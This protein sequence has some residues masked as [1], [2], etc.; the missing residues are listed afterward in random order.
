MK[1][2]GY[3]FLTHVAY[4][5]LVFPLFIFSIP[6]TIKVSIPISF[7]VANVFCVF[8][9]W[10][11]RIGETSPVSALSLLAHNGMIFTR[12]LFTAAGV[13]WLVFL[14][15]TAGFA[16]FAYASLI[17]LLFL[18][19][20]VGGIIVLIYT[21]RTKKIYAVPNDGTNQPTPIVGVFWPYILLFVAFGA[22]VLFS[23]PLTRQ[24]TS[25]AYQF[26]IM[27]EI[28][29]SSV[30]NYINEETNCDAFEKDTHN[31]ASCKLA[32]YAS[33]GIYK[34][35]SLDCT[36]MYVYDDDCA[37]LQA[38]QRARVNE[39]SSVCKSLHGTNQFPLCIAQ[40]PQSAVWKS[41][42]DE[43]MNRVLKESGN[44]APQLVVGRCLTRE[45]ANLTVSRS[46]LGRLF[47]SWG[48][49]EVPYKE[50][51][52]SLQRTTS[53]HSPHA[54][55]WFTEW[56]AIDEQ[57]TKYLES[58]NAN[59]NNTDDFGRT[60]LVLFM[61]HLSYLVDG[62]VSQLP[63][64][65]QPQVVEKEL[66]P[67]RALIAF[68]VNPSQRDLIGKNAFDHAQEIQNDVLR[69]KVIEI[70]QQFP[71]TPTGSASVDYESLK[72]Y[73]PNNFWLQG[74]ARGVQSVSVSLADRGEV[75]WSTDK[76]VTVSDGKWQV[77]VLIPGYK[78]PAGSYSVIVHGPDSP[79]GRMPEL[80]RETLIISY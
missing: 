69:D 7:A 75:F 27:G 51:Y 6:S 23:I 26:Y 55:V 80:V 10:L 30:A 73:A 56:G 76:P 24:M 70:M 41:A 62:T 29:V 12:R 15:L 61:N 8:V 1:R 13:G 74:T 25:Y 78:I 35:E 39:D 19:W 58:I 38:I 21:A 71:G 17:S 72:Q 43:I 54:P 34:R 33:E 11:M 65:Q 59:P 36:D 22:A 64:R 5:A 40:F 42:C 18:T 53:I 9:Q 66:A 2:I 57:T 14:V 49:Y 28:P 67:L 45:N 63:T 32:Q 79:N 3:I 31:Y 16:L 77:L 52:L 48:E 47:D 68:G 20:Y 60:A 4:L 50:N 37:R 46:G 44:F